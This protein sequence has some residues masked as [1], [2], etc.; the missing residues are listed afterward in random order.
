[1]TSNVRSFLALLVEFVNLFWVLSSLCTVLCVDRSLPRRCLTIVLFDSTTPKTW[2]WWWDSD[3]H[4]DCL[5][6]KGRKRELPFLQSKHCTLQIPTLLVH[7]QASPLYE[8]LFLYS[9]IYSSQQGWEEGT[10]LSSLFYKWG[11]WSH[12]KWESQIFSQGYLLS[13]SFVDRS[14]W[15]HFWV[16]ISH[17]LI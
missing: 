5:G 9:S 2:W 6:G 7:R 1:M 15:V 13:F 3:S 8:T 11:N 4:W 10:L 12:R 16:W 14:Y 17:H